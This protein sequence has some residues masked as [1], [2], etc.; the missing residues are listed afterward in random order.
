MSAVARIIQSG[1]WCC[2]GITVAY[3]GIMRSAGASECPAM[4]EMTIS[5]DG[6][7][8]WYAAGGAHY[9]LYMTPQW[10]QPRRM[11]TE[12]RVMVS[13]IPRSITSSQ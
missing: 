12:T 2:A 6:H 11:D 8:S 10:G 9:G 1:A 7:G 3:S 13:R 4:L 5:C